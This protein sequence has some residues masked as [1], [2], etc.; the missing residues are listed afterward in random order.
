MDEINLEDIKIILMTYHSTN[1]MTYYY[2]KVAK[3]RFNGRCILGKLLDGAQDCTFCRFN[4]GD[5]LD[6]GIYEMGL[7]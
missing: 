4:K 3:R 2:N 5:E 6:C 7:L 1:F